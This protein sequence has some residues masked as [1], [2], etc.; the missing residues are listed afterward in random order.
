MMKKPICYIMLLLTTLAGPGCK[1]FLD[2]Q[3]IDKLSGNNFYQSREDVVANIYDLSRKLFNK[4]NETHF[5]GATGEYRSGEVLSEPQSD[6]GPARAFVEVLGRN[7]LL[8]LLSGNQPW[9]FYN[10]NPLPRSWISPVSSRCCVTV[11]ELRT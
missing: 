8:T 3:P 1:K 4:V 11:M 5:I 10:S 9:G 7:D 2:I 6:V